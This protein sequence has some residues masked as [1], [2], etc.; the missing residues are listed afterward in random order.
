M[1]T[2]L[3]ANTSVINLFRFMWFCLT[4]IGFVV[5]LII[6]AS[7]WEKFQTNPTITGLDT[8]FHNWEVPFPAVTLCQNNPA[9]ESVIQDF[10]IK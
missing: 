10:V 5:S 1:E 7:L 8:D 3:Y 2:C 4:A 6:I 9:N